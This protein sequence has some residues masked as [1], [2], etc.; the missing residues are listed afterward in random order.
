MD[1]LIEGY[2]ALAKTLSA[3]EDYRLANAGDALGIVVAMLEH[4]VGCTHDAR[5]VIDAMRE[6]HMQSLDRTSRETVEM[7]SRIMA[8][9]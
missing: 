3:D 7:V 2:K 8:R 6:Q 9:S 4:Q 1:K 5:A